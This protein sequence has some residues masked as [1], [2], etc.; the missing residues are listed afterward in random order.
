MWFYPVMFMDR[1]SS[2]R[3]SLG[4][5]LA[6]SLEHIRVPANPSENGEG[7]LKRLVRALVHAYMLWLV[8]RLDILFHRWKT[9]TLPPPPVAP[10]HRAKRTTPRRPRRKNWL[11]DLIDQACEGQAPVMPEAEPA[12][13]PMA[14]AEAPSRPAPVFTWARHQPSPRRIVRARWWEDPG[15]A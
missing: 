4:E 11:A 5:N 13:C 2:F 14:L 1:S 7:A 8:T 10:L 9:G 6:Q 15:W 12:E 3:T